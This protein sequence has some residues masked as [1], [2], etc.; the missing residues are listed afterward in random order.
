MYQL[1]LNFQIC[2]HKVVPEILLTV[3]CLM[4]SKDV[5]F[6]ILDIGYLCHHLLF[7]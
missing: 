2:L 4:N 1:H 3:Y 5:P 7:S 6:F